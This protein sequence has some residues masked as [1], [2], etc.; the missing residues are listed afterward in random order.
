M[1]KILIFLF[2]T[3][4]LFACT[5]DEEVTINVD[6]SDVQISFEAFEGGAYLNYQLPNNSDIYYIVV[7][8]K[9]FKGK[10]IVKKSTYF[11]NQIKLL[12]FCDEMKDVSI[13]IYFSDKQGNI[14]KSFTKTFNTKVSSTVSVFNSVVVKTYWNGFRVNFEVP[15]RG[16]GFVNIG[17]VG[18]NIKTKEIDTLLV[19]TRP[20]YPGEHKI[21]YTN[22]ED[23]E[24]KDV[25][26]VVW[27]ED[28]RCNDVKK[29]VYPKIPIS[30]AEMFDCT[31][32]DFYGESMESES[33]HTG[34][35]YLFDQDK[36]GIN[37]I[38]N[39]DPK[40]YRFICPK[41]CVKNETSPEKS[42][43]TVDLK[44]EK[45]LAMAKVFAHAPV[46]VP[47]SHGWGWSFIREGSFYNLPNH[48]KFY[49]TNDKD[50]PVEECDELGEFYQDP[51]LDKSQ[52][53]IYPAINTS[54]VF[55]IEDM[56]KILQMD[57]TKIQVNFDP[58]DKKYRYLKFKVFETFYVIRSSGAIKDGLGQFYIE[59]LEIYTKAN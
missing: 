22:I 56:D 59:E 35:K 23:T 27:T 37:A 30:R 10:E 11:E 9:D 14:S 5:N 24:L 29:Q 12:G 49:G 6:P 25:D 40:G 3:I 55:T 54:N 44:E 57:D 48:I 13:E 51:L 34:W 41:K 50:A 28:F 58:S 4:S 45:C 19:Q 7:R 39:A 53:W 42:V 8:Y 20:M 46:R 1:K 31:N 2:I 15:E 33:N 38:T 16:D 47:N 17:Y 43:W 32:V 26:V 21:S 36:K 18:M 52:T